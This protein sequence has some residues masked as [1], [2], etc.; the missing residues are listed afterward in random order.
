[1]GVVSQ[2]LICGSKNAAYLSTFLPG[3]GFSH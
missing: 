2:V 3:L 1:M